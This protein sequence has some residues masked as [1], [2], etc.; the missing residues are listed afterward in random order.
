MMWGKFHS[1]NAL[2]GI[3]YSVA[4]QVFNYNVL[5]PG[6]SGYETSS[7]NLLFPRSVGLGVHYPG[8]LR[9]DY[10]LVSLGPITFFLPFPLV[11]D[12]SGQYQDYSPG[13]E[14]LETL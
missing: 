5:F 12:T 10:R 8:R 3:L 14:A 11:I 7:F 6:V 2:I 9:L 1:P 4:E 13:L